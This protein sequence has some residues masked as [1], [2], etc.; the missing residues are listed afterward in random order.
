MAETSST[1]SD[2]HMQLP[3]GNDGGDIYQQPPDRNKLTSK[4][5]ESVWKYRV[6]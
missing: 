3:V 1:T 4:E 2:K 5:I 6:E